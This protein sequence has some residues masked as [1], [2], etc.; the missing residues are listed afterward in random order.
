MELRVDRLKP[1]VAAGTEHSAVNHQ[2]TF[3]A[4]FSGLAPRSTMRLSD[5]PDSEYLDHSGSPLTGSRSGIS[6]RE[7]LVL[8]RTRAVRGRAADAVI[9]PGRASLVDHIQV[10]LGN[11]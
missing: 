8:D 4:I 9:A 5:N 1:Q 7:S 11:G 10:A 2:I 3:I 6:G